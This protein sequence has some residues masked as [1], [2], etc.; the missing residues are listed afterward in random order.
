MTDTRRYAVAGGIALALVLSISAV[1][2]SLLRANEYDVVAL[3]PPAPFH[4][5][6]GSSF[7]ADGSLLAG[8]ILGMSVHRVDVV[9][10][11]TRIVVGAPEGMEIGRAHV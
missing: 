6:H 5:I 7:A 8:D 9:T 10:G 3:V 4:G 11:K 1:A 2:F